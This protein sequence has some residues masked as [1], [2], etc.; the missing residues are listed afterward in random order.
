[1]PARI[2][3]CI[4]SE[5]SFLKIDKTEHQTKR[6]APL[7]QEQSLAQRPAPLRPPGVAAAAATA[8][9]VTAVWTVMTGRKQGSLC[10]CLTDQAQ[11]QGGPRLVVSLSENR[12]VCL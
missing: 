7:Q 12:V 8:A 6:I 3:S 4:P 10:L 5:I 1:V 2:N 11:E 9:V